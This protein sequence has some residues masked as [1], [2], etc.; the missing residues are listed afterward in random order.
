M[1]KAAKRT[2]PR[3]F[4]DA[5]RAAD[6]LC[7]DP[8]T[9]RKWV[10]DGRLEGE[11]VP[12]LNDRRFEWRIFVDQPQIAQVMAR[13]EAHPA[14]RSETP[15]SSDSSAREI[16]ELRAQLAELRAE[17]AEERARNAEDQNIQLVAAIQAMTDVL[18][19]FQQGTQH[20]QSGSAR[21]AN[22]MSALLDTMA[23]D[24]TPDSPEGI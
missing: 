11:K 6:L 9:V 15:A 18:G 8:R 1:S 16:A 7:C 5:A 22:V 2:A 10:E 13:T 23:A 21:L 4:I 17:R 20:F 24:N 14:P 19:E 12:S 3:P